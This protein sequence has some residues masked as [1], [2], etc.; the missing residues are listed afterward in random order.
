MKNQQITIIFEEES[1][2]WD[3][4]S[5]MM[6]IVRQWE[7]TPKRGRVKFLGHVF[8]EEH[9]GVHLLR[10]RSLLGTF[11]LRQVQ[12]TKTVPGPPEE[13]SSS[14]GFSSEEVESKTKR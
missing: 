6:K 14:W 7:P 12:A 8:G 3:L 11:L 13:E 4:S 10:N 9:C 2:D 5:T 1:S